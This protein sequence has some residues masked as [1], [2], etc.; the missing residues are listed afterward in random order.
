MKMMWP[1]VMLTA[2]LVS[3][4]GDTTVVTRCNK[5]IAEYGIDPKIKSYK[6][7]SRVCNNNKLYLYSKKPISGE[8]ASSLCKC[9]KNTVKN[10]DIYLKE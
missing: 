3:Y 9:F 10:R 6:G 2:V 4:A 7:W 1:L 8:D 5:L